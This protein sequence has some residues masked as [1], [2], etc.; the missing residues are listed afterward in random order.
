MS[1]KDPQIHWIRVASSVVANTATIAGAVAGSIFINPTESSTV[2]L[3]VSSNVSDTP[4]PPQTSPVKLTPFYMW[5][6]AG[7]FCVAFVCLLLQ[8]FAVGYVFPEPTA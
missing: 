1:I 7:I 8:L 4:A 2:N 3:Y 6:T 5:L